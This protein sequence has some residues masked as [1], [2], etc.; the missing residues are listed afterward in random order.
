MATLS[1]I[2][3]HDCNKYMRA[4]ATILR[5]DDDNNDEDDDDDEENNEH[6]M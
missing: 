1:L 6:E 2:I 4:S 3:T 5:N